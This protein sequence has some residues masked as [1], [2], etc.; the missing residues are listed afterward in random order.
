MG[1]VVKMVIPDYKPKSYSVSALRENEFDVTF[2]VYPNGRAS[3]YLDRLEVG[4][5]TLYSFGKHVARTRNGG[6]Y[7]GIA[8]FG[9]GIT[10][11]LPVAEAELEKGTAE[12]VVLVWACRYLDDTF[13]HDKLKALKEKHGEKFEL[14]YV[15]SRQNEPTIEQDQS[16][17]S[18]ITYHYGKRLSSRLLE[19]IFHPPSRETARFLTVGTKEMMKHADKM[20]TDIGYPMPQHHLLPK[21]KGSEKK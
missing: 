8:V 9:V 11:G 20:L 17:S 13:W 12:K 1:D 14:V 15:I 10:E 16:Y 5:S 3:G 2:K 4:S 21:V 6:T 7:V 18:N 19:E